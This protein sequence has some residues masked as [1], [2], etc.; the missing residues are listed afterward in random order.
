MWTSRKP[1]ASFGNGG[2]ALGTGDSAFAVALQ[3]DGKIV[4]AGGS[5]FF[6]QRFLAD[7][8]P[9]PRGTPRRQS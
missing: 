3:L 9:V 8:G 6:V 7:G 2:F 1:V 5:P 4:V